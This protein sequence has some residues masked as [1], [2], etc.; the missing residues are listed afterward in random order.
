MT[1][2]EGLLFSILEK[3]KFQFVS[4]REEKCRRLKRGWRIWRDNKILEGG[5]KLV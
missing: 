4:I 1:G 2:F 3:R 5:E